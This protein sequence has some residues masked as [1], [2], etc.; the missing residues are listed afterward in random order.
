MADEKGQVQLTEEKLAAADSQIGAGIWGEKL[1][2]KQADAPADKPADAPA[3]KPIDK[4]V[5][6]DEAAYV[7][8]HFGVDNIELAKQ[9]LVDL[10]AKAETPAEIKFANEETK[11]FYS[12]F[13]EEN[14]ED[15]LLDHLQNKKLISKA[16][17][18][19]VENAK[20]ATELLQTYY[21]FKYKDFN[22][23]EVRDHFNDQ[24]SKPAKPKQL[25][26]QDDD[27][28]KEQV[29]EWQSKCDA[30]DKRI[31][32]DAKMVKP[33]FSQ[34][35][36]QIVLSDINK[37]QAANKQPTQEELDAAKKVAERFIQDVEADVKKLSEISTLVKDEAVEIPVSYAYSDEERNVVV[38]QVK[39]FVAKGYDANVIFAK[40]WTDA[41]GHF[42]ISRMISDLAYL[43]NREK[44]SNKLANE[45]ASQRMKEY[46]KDK[47]HINVDGLN[48]S[49]SNGVLDHAKALEQ[50]EAAIWEGKK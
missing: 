34:F 19:N 26:E 31:V 18:A 36:S 25:A 23:D 46:T 50:V 49:N 48:N 28:Y 40:L 8:Q 38:E 42:D 29:S 45:G 12:Y 16:E 17:K 4:L 14:K 11:K 10:R 20:E 35:K 44:I 37:P 47:K 5:V 32:R 3:D 21:K 39:S 13:T 41:N 22:G 6:F 7:K 30:I 27:E 33:E 15:E 1:A 24:Y 9:Q 2:D 43:N